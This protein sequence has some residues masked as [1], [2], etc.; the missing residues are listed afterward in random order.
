MLCRD[1]AHGHYTFVL[2]TE[3]IPV[4]STVLCSS[5]STSFAVSLSFPKCSTRSA[6]LMN[7]QSYTFTLRFRF[8]SSEWHETTFTAQLS[9]EEVSFVKDYLKKN[10]Y[11]PY[12]AFE[13]DQPE[14]FERMMQAHMDAIVAY[15]NK[16]II[17]PGETPFTKETVDWE[18]VPCDFDWPEGFL[19]S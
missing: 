18:C 10:G 4:G 3:N 2:S 11:F 5:C 6:N 12:W 7:M 17:E 1:T 14:M 16:E 8:D 15:V 19:E 9:D 13:F